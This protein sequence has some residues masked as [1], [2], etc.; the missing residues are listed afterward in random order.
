MIYKIGKP[1]KKEAKNKLQKDSF[2]AGQSYWS[3]TVFYKAHLWAD[4]TEEYVVF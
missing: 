4:K 3:K 1:A 2:S